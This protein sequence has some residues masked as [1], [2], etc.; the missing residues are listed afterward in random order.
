MAIEATG[1]MLRAL[2]EW[3]GFLP[4]NQTWTELKLHFSTEYALLITPSVLEVLLQG[5]HRPYGETTGANA[6]HEVVP[7]E[8]ESQA[9]GWW[10]MAG[11]G[12][13][14]SAG[15]CGSRRGS[16]TRSAATER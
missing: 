2:L 3:R 4:E 15:R 13:C 14:R 7:V 1:L 11:S 12:S 5:H 10:R 8:R 9:G 6:G 16:H